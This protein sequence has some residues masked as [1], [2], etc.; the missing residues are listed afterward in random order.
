M[1]RRLSR[2]DRA[3]LTAALLL[4]VPVFGLHLHAVASGKLAW[5]GVYVWPAESSDRGPRVRD[6]LRG[7]GNE[8]VGLEIDDELLFAGA[9]DLRGLGPVGFYAAAL[10][11]ATP[12]AVIPLRVSRDGIL[13]DLEMR[14]VPLALRAGLGL[15]SLSFMGMA[16]L[17]LLRARDATVGRA[18]FLAQSALASAGSISRVRAAR[19]RSSGSASTLVSRS[20]GYPLVLRAILLLSRRGERPRTAGERLQSDAWERVP[21]A[22]S[23]VGITASVALFVPIGSMTSWVS[24]V[25]NYSFA[26]VALLAGIHAWR[27]ADASARRQIQWVVLGIG[28]TVVVSFLGAMV[29][30]ARPSLWWIDGWASASAVAVP[31]CIA[32]GIVRSNLLDIDRLLSA[33]ASST[34]IGIAVLAGVLLAVPWIAQRLAPLLPLG[35]DATQTVLSMLFA[36]VGIPAY[37]RLRPRIEAFLFRER[38]DLEAGVE[39]LLRD[40]GRCG[41][42]GELA[43]LVVDRLDALLR[44]TAVGFYARGEADFSPIARAGSLIAPGFDAAGGLVAR[45]SGQRTAVDAERV[46]EDRA[47]RIEP[48]ERAALQTL[49]TE[50][51]VPLHREDT[52]SG[53]LLLG[54]KRSGDVYSPGDRSLLSAVAERIS[55]EL[56]RFEA[57]EL[58]EQGLALQER[59]RDTYPT[60]WPS[61]STGANDSR[62]PSARSACCSST[63]GAIRSSPRAAAPARS[64]RW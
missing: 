16:V 8:A 33:A 59:L 6:F 25:A 36:A 53:F 41:G 28:I 10:E 5:T 31:I 27:Q 61:R 1:V 56:S 43:T 3:L 55:A 50:V 11:A 58:L 29:A 54:P 13:V 30:V 62:A 47:A 9:I 37:Q 17:V 26:F 4:F 52:L 19:S 45:L 38:V 22:F 35:A 21:W 23:A 24:F 46:L 42:A 51:A 15:I 63:S 14:A 7:M 49:R 20:V 12:E 2:L 57:R 39:T 48:R 60:R 40:L 18:F 44:P 34:A 64:S 32:I